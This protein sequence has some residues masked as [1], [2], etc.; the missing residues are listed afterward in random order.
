MASVSLLLIIAAFGISAVVVTIFTLVAHFVLW[1]FRKNTEIR[2][3][4]DSLK[5]LT[6]EEL[7]NA[8]K[9]NGKDLKKAKALTGKKLEDAKAKL[10]E[11]NMHKSKLRDILR[12]DNWYPSLSQFQCVAW[13]LIIGF[14]FLGVYLTRVFGGVFEIQPSLPVNLFVL[15]GI[16]VVGVPVASSRISSLKYVSTSKGNPLSSEEIKANYPLRTMLEENKKASLSRFQMFIWTFIAI[17]IYLSIFFGMLAKPGALQAVEN[18]TLPDIDTTLLVLMGISQ[19]AYIG[20]KV[21]ATQSTEITKIYPAVA[22]ADDTVYVYGINFG[23]DKDTIQFKDEDGKE[24][25]ID[26]ADISEWDDNRITFKV[27]DIKG[28]LKI[29]GKLRIIILIKGS[30]TV[31]PPEA[32]FCFEE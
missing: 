29:D 8:K 1:S 22:K 15:M 20:G 24:V 12:D 9:L 32:S 16:S 10:R 5:Q 30:M 11:A 25:K 6:G 31:S 14:L 23:K 26:T 2:K 27:P 19:G 18:L 17:I 21:I 28:Q 7:Q 13:T 4:K 3:I